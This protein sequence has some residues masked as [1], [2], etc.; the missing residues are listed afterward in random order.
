ML[1]IFEKKN[2]LVA[3]IFMGIAAVAWSLFGVIS[4]M[5]S[6]VLVPAILFATF[7]HLFAL[8]LG[9]VTTK[10][11]KIRLQDVINDFIVNPNVR[12]YIVW[13]SFL[14]LNLI[15]FVGGYFLLD[16]K[17]VGVV[18]A[19]LAP[20]FMILSSYVF[21]SDVYNKDSNKTYTWVLV[22]FAL[23]GVVL[24]AS[25]EAA[26]LDDF[27]SS[28]MLGMGLMFLGA[29]AGGVNSI[30]GNKMVSLVK[31]NSK[32][33][34]AIIS[35]NAQFISRLTT[36]LLYI[37]LC[38]FAY[39]FNFLNDSDF[40]AL[41][42]KNVVML[43]LLFGFLTG[44][45]QVILT[46]IAGN[47]ATNHSIYLIWFLA[48]IMG[49]FLLWY[50]DYGEINSTVA[51]SFIL[52]LVPNILLNLDIEDSFSFRVTFIWIL[53]F[54]IILFYSQGVPVDTETYFNSTN[55]LLVFFALMV[56][57]LISKLNER[58]NFREQL[59]M[60]FLH[61]I[62]ADGLAET[63]IKSIANKFQQSN[64]RVTENV[65]KKLMDCGIDTTKYSE[66][67][68]FEFIQNRRLYNIG[69][70]FVLLLISLLLISITIL[71]R[72]NNF[73]YDSYAFIINTAVIFTLAQVIERMFFSEYK[74]QASNNIF[75][76]NIISMIFLITLIIAIVVLF[77]SKYN[78]NII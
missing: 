28:S 36:M 31:E 13:H 16:N 63:T 24:L 17:I 78:F 77:L 59:F 74:I 57:Y 64:N 60:Q 69:E 56:G 38:G 34:I 61:K 6:E 1:D 55:A 15:L 14:N 54:T 21:F 47:I 72:D 3:A 10:L 25:N 11:S 49:V 30:V 18:I 23:I 67:L 44:Y 39:I 53:L 27:Y 26:N 75:V 12:K 35:I 42:N 22:V 73:L 62:R 41:L 40:T 43:A 2:N 71:Y 70:L 19:E 5:A 4:S 58:S 51:L 48:P 50:F 29:M 9:F 46:R 20:V 68:D 8:I 7:G 33:N 37:V 52:I 65:R 66:L 32:E 45:V 76:E